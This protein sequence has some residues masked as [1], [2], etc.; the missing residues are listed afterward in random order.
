MNKI[1]SYLN[2]HVMGEA[3]ASKAMRARMSRDNSVLKI[4]PELVVFP[5]STNDIRKVARFAW[6]MA[7]KV[8]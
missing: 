6:Q 2:E 5:R 3:V 7:E 4:T 1:A 8:M